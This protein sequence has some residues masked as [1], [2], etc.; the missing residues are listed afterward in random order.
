[1]QGEVFGIFAEQNVN[2]PSSSLLSTER[3]ATN[4]SGPL[5]GYFRYHGK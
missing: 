2:L 1:M 4:N 5:P 3:M